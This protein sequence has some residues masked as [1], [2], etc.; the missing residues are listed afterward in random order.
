ML[1]IFSFL[2]L[3]SAIAALYLIAKNHVVGWLTLTPLIAL[4][5]PG[6]AVP[7]TLLLVRDGEIFAFHRALLAAPCGLALVTV[8]AEGFRFLESKPRYFSVMASCTLLIALACAVTLSP[9][10]PFYNRVWNT[11]SQTPRDLSWSGLVGELTTKRAPL[12]SR[13]L[14]TS[15]VGFVALSVRQPTTQGASRSLGITA[16]EATFTLKL[17]IAYDQIGNATLALPDPLQLYTPNS[18]AAIFSGH[19][20]PL[21]LTL[22]CSGYHELVALSQKNDWAAISPSSAVLF[23]KR[24]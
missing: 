24:D 19:W 10:K 13:I 1:Q 5:L 22:V 17:L 11:T 15:D 14:A 18:T 6:I 9:G 20:P 2:G 23:R 3:S 8:A 16:H 7:F 4:L 12:S 21:D